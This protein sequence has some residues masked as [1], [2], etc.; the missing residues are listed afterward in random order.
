[1]GEPCADSIRVMHP[2]FQMGQGGSIPTSALQL[3]IRKIDVKRA[4]ELNRA[5]HSRLPEYE[6]GFCLNATVCYVAEHDGL[7]YAV[8]I[9]SNPTARLLPQDTWLELKRMAIAEDAPKNTASRML[10]IMARLIKRERPSIERLISYQ[11]VETHRGTI[12]RA[13]GWQPV[14]GHKG[15]SWCRP[16]SKNYSGTPRLRPDLNDATGAKVRWERAI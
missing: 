8:A 16:N 15:G 1:M 5:W 2:L 12:Y 10:A 11:D 6:T 7:F 3:R 13:A 14:S 9:W 4:Q